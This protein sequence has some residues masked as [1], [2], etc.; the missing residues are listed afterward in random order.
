MATI[1]RSKCTTSKNNQILEVYEQ[2]LLS[3]K[4]Q[5][6]KSTIKAYKDI[7][8]RVIIPE[9]T[10]F[11]DGYMS[12][13]TESDLRMLIDEYAQTHTVGGVHFMYRHLKAFINWYWD[14]NEIDTANPI[15]K[16]KVKKPKL[17]PQP[18]ISRPEVEL[19]LKAAKEH[20][21]FPERDIAVVMILC[22]T[23]IRLSSLIN[24]KISDINSVKHELV[25]WG[26]DQEFH[27][28]PL[29]S[30]CNRALNKYLKCIVDAQPNDPLW[31]QMDG[32]PL[33]VRGIKEILRRLCKEAEIE[34]YSFHDFRRFYGLEL[35]KSTHDIYFVSRALNH[36]SIEVTKRYLAIDMIEDMEA[37]RSMSPMDNNKGKIKRK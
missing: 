18:G 15:R 13:V 21:F 20:S 16:I 31:M 9:L 1:N 24:L 36:H 3:R 32:T 25:I 35:Y 5:C 28:K 11:C 34:E 6:A 7:G 10:K 4:T 22:D 23:G 33:N 17:P 19:V 27:I 14:E 8:E 26:K 2:F 29:G 37:I 30:M 12:N